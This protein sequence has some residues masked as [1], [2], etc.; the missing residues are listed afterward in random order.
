M[1]QTKRHEPSSLSSD[2]VISSVCRVM[3]A[4]LAAVTNLANHQLSGQIA[5]RFTEDWECEPRM[6]RRAFTRQHK[7][8]P[9]Q[10]PPQQL[11]HDFCLFI[12]PCGGLSVLL[13]FRKTELQG[14]LI[15]NMFFSLLWNFFVVHYWYSCVGVIADMKWDLL[16]LW[17]LFEPLT[18]CVW[19]F[20]PTKQINYTCSPCGTTPTFFIYNV[21]RQLL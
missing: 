1:T 13:D 5:L 4:L 6:F 18:C 15:A 2:G 16:M 12:D 10:K 14:L 11:F 8:R 7:P 20:P 17:S 19:R 21:Y 9:S 3:S